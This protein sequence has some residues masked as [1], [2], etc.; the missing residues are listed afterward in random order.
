MIQT[1]PTPE[2]AV[3]L[4]RDLIMQ[5]R[6]DPDAKLM[7]FHHADIGTALAAT[8]TLSTAAPQP[9]RFMPVN[10]AAEYIN[11]KAED[12]LNDH[13]EVDH[14]DGSQVFQYGEAGRDYYNMLSELA[15]E[16]R[17]LSDAPQPSGA[18]F[19]ADP[20]AEIT[21]E[22]M[23]GVLHAF[24]IDTKLSVYGFDSLQ[25]SGTN[26]PGIQG[27]VR[28]CIACLASGEWPAPRY[29]FDSEGNVV[30]RLATSSAAKGQT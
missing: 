15:D 2:E 1:P 22:H 12:Y 7:H 4:L 29:D 9:N 16:I 6:A 3:K 30:R 13:S 27:I 17:G 14:T 19:C 8:A 28:M 23:I 11:K 21:D 18:V 5:L 24:G 26:V 20:S 10:Q 25:V